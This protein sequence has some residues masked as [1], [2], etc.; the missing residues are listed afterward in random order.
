MIYH[1]KIGLAFFSSSSGGSSKCFV[2]V[3]LIWVNW[4]R[5][6]GQLKF[7]FMKFFFFLQNSLEF[8]FCHTDMS[9]L[10]NLS[11]KVIMH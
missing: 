7:H 4:P 3:S 11:L 8:I 5:I 6:K 9:S 1:H 10:K 2:S